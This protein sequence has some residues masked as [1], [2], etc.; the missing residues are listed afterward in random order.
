M[1]V[2]KHIS[3]LLYSHDCVIVPGFGGFIAN[4]K[5]AQVNFQTDRFSPPTKEVSFNVNLSQDDGLLINEISFK[6]GL[7]YQEAKQLVLAEVNT[8]LDRL[9]SGHSVSIDGIGDLYTDKNRLIQ[10]EPEA[11]KNFL[12]DAYGLSSFHYPALKRESE[13]WART[14]AHKDIQPVHPGRKRL[15]R[16]VTIGLPLVIAIAFVSANW[17]TV[18]NNI[19][20][21]AASFNPFKFY[22]ESTIKHIPASTAIDGHNTYRPGT[23]E[24]TQ[25]FET[26]KAETEEVKEVEAIAIKEYYLIAGSFNTTKRANKLVNTLNRNGFKAE[27]LQKDQTTIRVAYSSF[28]S[29]REA[30]TELSKIR[31]T[32]KDAWL[33]KQ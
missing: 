15:S 3:R 22:T 10:F 4:T 25:I 9:H 27:I 33:L 24:I 28:V 31:K 21:Q 12:L 23:K 20:T 7:S 29:K 2:S 16:K 32:N 19:N 18:S 17:N 6:L 1:K 26:L 5:P 11:N 30:L 13:N 14:A 8:W